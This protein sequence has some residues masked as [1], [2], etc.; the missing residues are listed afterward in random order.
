MAVV[1]MGG[2]TGGGGRLLG[3]AVANRLQ[4]DYVDR[5]ILANAARH[6]GATVEALHQREERPLT[7]GERF[8]AILQRILERSAVAG[9][10]DDPYLGAG[11]VAYLTQEYEE[12]PRST[13]TKGHELEDDEYIGAIRRVFTDLSA[14]GNVVIVGRGGAIILRHVPNALRVGTVARFEDRVARVMEGERLEWEHAKKIVVDRDKARAAYFKRFFDIDNPDDPKLYHLVLNTSDMNL[15]YATEVVV[16][17]C[18]ALEDGRL[19]QNEGA[20]A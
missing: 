7:R 20:R 2:L 9:A 5:L 19:P 14:T 17:A 18:Q 13:I 11:A 8:S 3:P 6:V 4:A 16:Q 12:L 15:E 1:T 10:G